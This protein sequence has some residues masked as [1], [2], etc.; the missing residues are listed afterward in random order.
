MTFFVIYLM[1]TDSLVMS[2]RG[3]AYMRVI[4]VPM[5]IRSALLMGT[6]AI[7]APQQSAT[8]SVALTWTTCIRTTNAGMQSCGPRST[9][10]PLKIAGKRLSSPKGVFACRPTDPFTQGTRQLMSPLIR[11]STNAPG[12]MWEACLWHAFAT[13]KLVSTHYTWSQVGIACFLLP[14]SARL[15][16]NSNRKSWCNLNV[17]QMRHKS[18]SW[19]NGV[20]SRRFNTPWCIR[21]AGFMMMNISSVTR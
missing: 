20:G 3:K 15:T 1:L 5:A 9:L 11:P 14:A 12:A 13:T 18:R 21:I 4:P 19:G 2:W 8:T 16:M 10:V 17:H 7:A 6:G